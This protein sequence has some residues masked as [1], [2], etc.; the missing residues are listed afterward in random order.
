ML[1]V[2]QILA[3][4][5]TRTCYHQFEQMTWRS[6]NMVPKTWRKWSQHGFKIIRNKQQTTS[7]NHQESINNGAK[8][9]PRR[10]P[11]G[12]QKQKRILHPF[13]LF[14]GAS[15]APYWDPI[16]TPLGSSFRTFCTCVFTS[17]LN[18]LRDPIF[19]DFG[20]I[21]ASILELFLGLFS[22]L[23]I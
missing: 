6:P 7:S 2:F 12:S 22:D 14:S 15:W 21:L 10:V 20:T 1:Q 19:I 8:W 11:G 23:W 17:V 16:G 5:M 18:K 9:V 4:T 3:T 13:S